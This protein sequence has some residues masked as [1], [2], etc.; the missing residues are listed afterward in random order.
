MT[1][2]HKS[3]T[4]STMDLSLE[5]AVDFKNTIDDKVPCDDYDRQI[6]K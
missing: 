4:D 2:S 5:I 1:H 3:H 6:R